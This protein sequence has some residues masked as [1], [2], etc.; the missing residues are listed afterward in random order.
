MFRRIALV[1]ALVA[2]PLVPTAMAQTDQRVERVQFAPGTS[3]TT[4]RDRITGYEVVRY[5]L[6]AQAG[7]RMTVSLDTSNT[8]T[9]F[10]VVQPSQP[11]G[12]ALASSEMAGSNPMVPEINRFDGI[13]PESG[14]FAI[15]VWMYRA[16]ARRGEVADFTLEVSIAA[17]G[18]D[19]A[20]PSGDYADGLSGGPD[21][22][23][24]QVENTLNVRSAP[25]A[26]AT[27]IARLPK[28]RI[29]EN[30]GCRMAE[31]RRWCQIADGDATGWVAGDYLVESA[32]PAGDV[33]YGEGDATNSEG[34]N[35]TGEVPCATSLSAPM[36]Q[37]AFG[38]IRRGGGDA[39]VVVTLPGGGQRYLY[40]DGDQSSS[41]G[42]HTVWE[43][44]GDLNMIQV[45]DQERYE[46]PDAVRFGG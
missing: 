46:I 43:R 35:A 42:G 15:E 16:A 39:T 32:A 41:D 10:N 4:I 31:G 29:V 27:T 18:G 19:T 23:A 11:Q 25:S 37:C 38:V 44:R 14:D 3:G 9:Y 40:F 5:M 6:G 28:G 21:W 30:R 8:S 1:A 13:L 45:G 34:Y 22:W 24:V 12:P 17:G 36:G 26:S 33:A 2:A 7:Q 20:A